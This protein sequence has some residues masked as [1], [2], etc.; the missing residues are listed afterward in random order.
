M[1]PEKFTLAF[2]V[3]DRNPTRLDAAE[4]EKYIG[5]YYYI[6][7]KNND[8]ASHDYT[9]LPAVICQDTYTAAGNYNQD[10]IDQFD[11]LDFDEISVM[12]CPDLSSVDD[13]ISLEGDPYY[14]PDG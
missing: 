5:F 13:T 3:I 6:L 2:A 1:T 11:M 8:G 10:F 12:Y 4:I 9:Y 7:N 14:Y